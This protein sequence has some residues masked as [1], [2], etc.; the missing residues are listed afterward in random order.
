MLEAIAVALAGFAAGII[1]LFAGFTLG[2]EELVR[3]RRARRA[4][5]RGD[6]SWADLRT[7]LPALVRRNDATDEDRERLAFLVHCAWMYALH[8][9]PAIRPVTAERPALPSLAF[10]WLR[11][12]QPLHLLLDAIDLGLDD[13]ALTAHLDG[14][15]VL[16][17]DSM[18]TLLAL[19][20][21]VVTYAS[22]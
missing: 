15:N 6:G 21:D 13:T 2:G 8:P 4:L 14:T 22:R 3:R 19:R 18:R 12:G 11:A 10:T 17:P 20:A 9:N 7:Y 16:D 5:T 1:V